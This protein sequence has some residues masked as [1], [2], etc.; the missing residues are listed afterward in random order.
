[1]SKKRLRLTVHGSINGEACSFGVSARGDI[2][3][4]AFDQVT[5]QN[6]LAQADPDTTTFLNALKTYCGQVVT[7]TGLRVRMWDDAGVLTQL[8]ERQFAT[9]ITNS[10]Q[11]VLPGYCAA[12]VTLLT[13][14]PGRRYRG[15]FYIPVTSTGGMS[16]GKMST[17]MRDAIALAA[18]NWLSAL[19]N[20]P[21]IDT[22]VPAFKTVVY[23]DALNGG[24]TDISKVRVGDVMDLQRR[25]N[26]EQLETFSLQSL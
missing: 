2:A 1:M 24:T 23:S 25:R 14:R 11:S 26:N 5:A 8:A 9:P 17:A 7:W 10:N 3:V 18:K 21:G 15:R 4:D 20:A 19:D 16:Q 6:F 12:V 22:L 13:D